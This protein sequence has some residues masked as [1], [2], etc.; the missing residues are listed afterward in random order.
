MMRDASTAE[1][2]R[3]LIAQVAA[4]EALLLAASGIHK[5]L[6][7]RHT[8]SVIQTFGGV[9]KSLAAAAAAAVIGGEWLA[10][11]ALLM[12]APRT[13]GAALAA[14]IWGGYLALIVRAVARGRR[15][16]DCGCSFGPTRHALGSHHIAR[17][18]VLMGL[19]LSIAVTVPL[20]HGIPV[21]GV[22]V[23][24]A[25][26]LL[27]LYGALDQ[28]MALQPPRRGEM[29]RGEMGRGVSGRGESI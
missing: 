20:G 2:L 10:G 22:Q 11:A 13:L 21:Q 15:D 3:L 8:L 6:R 25:C 7:W 12:P 9:P 26:T 28:V 4:F 1:V 23:L 29:G 27:A 18:A 19:A 14:L 5:A 16:V 17:N 24:A